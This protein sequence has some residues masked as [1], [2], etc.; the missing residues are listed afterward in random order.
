VAFAKQYEPK[1]GMGT[2]I[3]NMMPFSISFAIVWTILL[4]LFIV[5]NIPLGPDGGIYYQLK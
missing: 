2:I 4:I 1:T 5:F 3:A